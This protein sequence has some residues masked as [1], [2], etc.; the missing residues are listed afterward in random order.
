MS[1][2]GLFIL[3]AGFAASAVSGWYR[4]IPLFVAAQVLCQIGLRI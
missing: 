4:S 2:L 3:S 1:D